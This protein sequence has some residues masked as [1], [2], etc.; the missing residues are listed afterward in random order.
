MSWERDEVSGHSPSSLRRVGLCGC[1]EEG[2]ELIVL[3]VR[4]ICTRL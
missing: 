3:G 1:R 4:D 2:Y